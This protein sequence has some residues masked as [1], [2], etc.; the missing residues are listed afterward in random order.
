MD[1]QQISLIDSLR[2]SGRLPDGGPIYTETNLPLYVSTYMQG[3]HDSDH[4][5]IEPW[6]AVSAG[7]FLGIVLYWYW[8]WFRRGMGFRQQ[9]FLAFALPILAI[10][11]LGGTV[12]HAFR[13]YPAFLTLDWMPI[14]ILCLA[15]SVYFFAR[16]LPRWWMG[17][18]ALG[19]GFALSSLVFS[20]VRLG[21]VPPSLAVSLNYV[22]MGL[23]ILMP[24]FLWLRRTAYKDARWVAAALGAFV[25]A[26]SCRILDHS[27]GPVMAMGAH[28]LWHLFGALAS[29]LMITYVWKTT[30][31][32]AV[33]QR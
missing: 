5:L 2:Q 20:T 13:K 23:M 14:M 31:S 29:H 10:G 3:G 8:Q 15:T 11:G 22:V 19:V 21:W 18:G 6:N 24:V 33:A 16:V 4:A 27:V 12:Y 32:S 30:K 25:L 17:F 9:P 26:V 28:W 1:P 7:L